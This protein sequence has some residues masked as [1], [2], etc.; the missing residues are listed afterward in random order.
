MNQTLLLT[1]NQTTASIR[2]HV[3]QDLY[4][5]YDRSGGK[6]ST[7]QIKSHDTGHKPL[8]EIALVQLEQLQPAV[9][10][11]LAIRQDQVPKVS[12]F[13][14]Y[15]VPPGF[16]HPRTLRTHGSWIHLTRPNTYCLYQATGIWP[17][18]WSTGARQEAPACEHANMA[19]CTVYFFDHLYT[20]GSLEN[21]RNALNTMHVK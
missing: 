3:I 1:K 18:R 14:Q 13:C 11:K 9:V 19:N 16:V 12:V 10:H 4:F 7:L 15:G 21:S 5:V 17:L 2:H 8:R 20:A 6:M